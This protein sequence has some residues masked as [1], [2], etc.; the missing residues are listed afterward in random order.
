MGKRGWIHGAGALV[1]TTIVVPTPL[2]ASNQAEP[3][4]GWY[5]GGAL[6][7]NDLD[8]ARNE[9]RLASG[10]GGGGGLVCLLFPTAPGC[11][12]GGGGTVPTGFET[13][14]D[15]GYGAALILG[16]QTGGALRPEFELGYL[17][18]DLEDASTDGAAA[19]D[20]SGRTDAVKAMGNLWYDID[21]GA[22]RPYL[23]AGLGGVQVRMAEI[24]IDGADFADDEDI[25]FA[26]QAGA[27]IGYIWDERTTVSLDYRYLR[28]DDPS[29]DFAGGNGTFDS[30]YLGQSLMLGLRYVFATPK[31]LQDTDGD[32]VLNKDD[33]CPGTPP[34]VAV[35]ADG[36][37]LDSDGD[38]VPNYRDKCPN[39]PPGAPVDENGCPLD[40]DGDT[41]PDYSDQ[42]PATPAGARVLPNG[43]TKMT[44]SGDKQVNFAFDSAALTPSAEALLD[45][46]AKALTDDPDLKIG[47][48][49]HTDNVGSDA[50][51]LRLSRERANSVAQYL[52]ANGVRDSQIHT[53]GFGEQKPIAS[54]DTE[55]GRL[56]NRRVEII[57]EQP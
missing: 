34:G 25:V 40:S 46:V 42:C 32:G 4:T 23:G 10:G 18:N 1:L 3:A 6:G 50:Y 45:P 51:N 11:G 31:Q 5:I 26:W 55:H 19:S 57:V 14:Y 27:G 53:Q 49:G 29:F 15:L 2:W 28:P 8:E 20:V 56:V 36:C 7:V 21:L 44:L 43:C 41:V 22:F 52:L 35:G 24:E 54:N 9:G 37:P 16:Y 17:R 13:E 38:G 30:E 12:G 47:I 48:E 33:Q 39:T